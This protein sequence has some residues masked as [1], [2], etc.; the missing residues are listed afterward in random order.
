M[1]TV[2]IKARWVFDN[3]G[4]Y[5]L[6]AKNTCIATIEYSK[7]FGGRL[8]CSANGVQ[9]EFTLSSMTFIEDA[10]KWCAEQLEAADKQE[11]SK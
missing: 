9:K 6:M 7:Y 8:Y 10:Q 1:K 11:E 5:Q 4:L 3:E 2:V